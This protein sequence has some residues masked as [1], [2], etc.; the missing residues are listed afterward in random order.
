MT[1][2]SARRFKVLFLQAAV[3][4]NATKEIGLRVR[5]SWFSF[6]YF[7]VRTY[8]ADYM[9]ARNDGKVVSGVAVML[10][11]LAG[12]AL[13]HIIVR[14]QQFVNNNTLPYAMHL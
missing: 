4:A 14:P 7:C 10:P 2:P 1:L 13:I 6:E 11:Q 5:C 8:Y 12:R 3:F 9:A